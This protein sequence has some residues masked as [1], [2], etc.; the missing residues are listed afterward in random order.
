[1]FAFFFALRNS[2]QE[3]F[4]LPFPKGY[5]WNDPGFPTLTVHYGTFS[6]FFWSGHTGGSMIIA[7]Q[8]YLA[9]Q[10]KLFG[11][12]VFNTLF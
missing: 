11:L 6:D 7:M 4:T 9:K 3:I 8:F 2:T 1:M 5:I 12:G 10:W